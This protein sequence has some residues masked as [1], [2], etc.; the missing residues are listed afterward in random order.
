MELVWFISGILFALVILP[1]LNS[2]MELI[3]AWFE[4]KRMKC[5]EAINNSN[6]NMQKAASSIEEQYSTRQIG[7]SLSE[8]EEEEEN[9]EDL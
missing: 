5:A 1:L 9:Y 2:L 4:T 6:I 3:M 8:E 7:F